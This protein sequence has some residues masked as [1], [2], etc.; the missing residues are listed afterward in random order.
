[1]KSFVQVLLGLHRS[2]FGKER[3]MF[4]PV[5]AAIVL[6]SAGVGAFAQSVPSAPTGVA[7]VPGNSQVTV[8]WNA[9][10]PNGEP[11]TGY[12][13]TSTPGSFTCA[14]TVALSCTVKGLTNGT[15]YVFTV[16]ATD[17]LGTSVGTTSVGV[18]PF[19]VPGAP[20]N[21]VGTSGNGS[22]VLTWT[23]P[24]SNGGSAI[25]S[26][27][28]AA[29]PGG[30]TCT[31]NSGTP[32]T[33]GCTV[34]GLTNDTLYV[35]TVTATN[36]AGT[37][38]ISAS[39]APVSPATVP[40]SPTSVTGASGDSAVVVSWAPP[41]SNGG[42]AITSYT[43]TAL[44]FGVSTGLTCTSNT[45]SPV[46]PS[47]T[48]TGLANGAPYT[49]IV[50]ATNSVGA[51]APSTPSLAATAGVPGVPTAVTGQSGNGSLL[52]S[53]TAPAFAGASPITSYTATST[54]GTLTCTSNQGSP[55][56][57]RCAWAG[58]TNGNLYVFT[59]TATNAFGT[60]A[61][62][63]PSVPVGPATVPGAPTA[64]TAVY[65]SNGP[66]GQ[67]AIF[68]S[69]PA[70]NGGSPITTYTV[71]SVQDTSKHCS[72]DTLYC[73]VTGLNSTTTYTFTVVAT[74]AR[75][76]GAASAASVTVAGIQSS[77]AQSVQSLGLQVVGSSVTM[78]L[79]EFSGNAKV[80]I[81]DLKGRTVWSKT[82][83]AGTGEV[84]WDGHAQGGTAVAG[85]YFVRFFAPGAHQGLILAAQS[86]IFLGL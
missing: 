31:S 28:A 70:S 21:V 81:L 24:A 80:S 34:T 63:A 57:P 33:A 55:I 13:V 62:S 41:A 39:S 6:L 7:G 54:S 75:G 49:F 37:G 74:N 40:G 22:V 14:T 5:I 67:M 71:T 18:V 3:E 58:L 56:T 35:F 86:R 20:T 84:V 72:T 66:A 82:V 78:R 60:S 51:G 1:M 48:V 46:T 11:V 25:T 64:V 17:S 45:G 65:D 83:G 59:V 43:V 32:I 77:L 50:T 47:C 68:W 69:A 85:I 53:W 79:P 42:S 36:A 12:T 9:S 44:S 38:G 2:T 19:T 73:V 52:L 61:A 29:S 10:V 76:S 15:A 16:T 8:S 26:Y 30:A 27:T 4:K 23:A